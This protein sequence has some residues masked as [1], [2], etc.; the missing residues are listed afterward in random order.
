MKLKRTKLAGESAKSLRQQLCFG[1]NEVTR[2][3]E[4]DLVQLVV[5]CKDVQVCF[6]TFVFFSLRV[7]DWLAV[8]A[9]GTAYSNS[10]RLS[11]CCYGMSV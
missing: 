11:E 1:I 2:G 5:V 7:F 9:V 10:V 6:I 8:V 3:L 4:K